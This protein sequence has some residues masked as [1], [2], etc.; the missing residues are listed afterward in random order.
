MFVTRES[1]CDHVQ[2]LKFVSLT[3]FEISNL[4]RKDCNKY[5]T[6][7]YFFLVRKGLSHKENH[8]ILGTPLSEK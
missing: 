5:S 2:W 6:A 8:C 7:V 4:R 3:L 1:R